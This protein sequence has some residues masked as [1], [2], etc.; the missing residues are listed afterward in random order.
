M[1]AASHPPSDPE[2][3]ARYLREGCERSFA[4]LVDVH[5]RMVLGTALRRTSVPGQFAISQKIV[6]VMFF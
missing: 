1:T 2:L 4:A 3:L 6:F 5:Q